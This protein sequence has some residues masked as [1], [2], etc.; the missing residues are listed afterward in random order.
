MSSSLPFNPKIHF[1][2]ETHTNVHDSPM[3]CE[4]LA[5]SYST[6]KPLHI[7]TTLLHMYTTTRT[8]HTHFSMNPY[9]RLAIHRPVFPHIQLKICQIDDTPQ[10]DME[11]MS[12]WQED[13]LYLTP[14][15]FDPIFG[16]LLKNKSIEQ[17]RRGLNS[18]SSGFSSTKDTRSLLPSIQVQIQEFWSPI[19]TPRSTAPDFRN[20][21][22]TSMP[23][24]R[25]YPDLI[26]HH[27]DNFFLRNYLHTTQESVHFLVSPFANTCADYSVNRLAPLSRIGVQ[28]GDENVVLCV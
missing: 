8:I 5:C 7:P 22:M 1:S 9:S 4:Q 12:Y 6:F 23:N 20:G 11:S 27:C 13:E 15:K 26:S 18:Q 24:L 21:E 3:L 17:R 2:G 14:T 19:P 16:A 10:R 28:V 25:D